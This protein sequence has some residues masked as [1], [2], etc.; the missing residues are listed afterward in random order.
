MT[1]LFRYDMG[2]TS[3]DACTPHAEC[4]VCMVDR[5][6]DPTPP[7]SHP[8]L[9]PSPEPVMCPPK[10]DPCDHTIEGFGGHRRGG[11]RRGGWGRRG[12][13]YGYGYN[14]YYYPYYYNTV[15]V[16]TKVVKTEP[17]QEENKTTSVIALMALAIGIMALMN[18]R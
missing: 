12:F 11:H 17:K 10:G 15:P 4:T 5:M 18:R 6:K 7:P 16:V 14:P 2:H 9:C 13:R 1:S 3:S 8:N